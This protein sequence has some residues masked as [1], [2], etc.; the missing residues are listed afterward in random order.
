MNWGSIAFRG[1]GNA[2]GGFVVS[3]EGQEKEPEVSLLLLFGIGG[4]LMM[5][6]V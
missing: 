5:L 6:M 3:E 4:T 2:S 1:L